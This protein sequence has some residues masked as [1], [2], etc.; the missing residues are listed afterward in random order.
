MIYVATGYW[1]DD[2]W[3]IAAGHD[4]D[5]VEGAADKY[6]CEHNGHEYNEAGMFKNPDKNGHAAEGYH[7]EEVEETK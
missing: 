6:C 7:V 1:C 5:K 2:H 4:R 3:V